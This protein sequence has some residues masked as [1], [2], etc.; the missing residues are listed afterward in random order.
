MQLDGNEISSTTLDR[1]QAL[2]DLFE[3]AAE[4]WSG[5]P[6][7]EQNALNDLQSDYP[8]GQCIYWGREAAQGAQERLVREQMFDTEGPNRAHSTTLQLTSEVGTPLLARLVL[9]GDGYG[10]WNK[11][12]RQWARTHGVGNEPDT[13]APPMVAFFD[14]RFGHTPFGQFTGHRFYV[15]TL[16]AAHRHGADL[17]QQDAVAGWHIDA[18]TRQKVELWLSEH[19]ILRLLQEQQGPLRP[20]RERG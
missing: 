10:A 12:T 20:Q 3:R 16:L 6:G 4:I 1:V 13:A 19:P 9:R 2:R 17:P 14:R 15:S 11:E 8:L 18:N 7:A 5:V